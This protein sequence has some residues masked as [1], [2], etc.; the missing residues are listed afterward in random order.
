MREFVLELLHHEVHLVARGVVGLNVNFILRNLSEVL[1][2]NFEFRGFQNAVANRL[3]GHFQLEASDG[4]EVELDGEVA[5]LCGVHFLDVLSNVAQFCFLD[6]SFYNSS[7]NHRVLVHEH[8]CDDRSADFLGGVDDFL[9]S[10]NTQGY[11]H[12]SN[13]SEMESF[14]GHLSGWLS[15]RLGSNSAT[16]FA[17]HH[18]C[19]LVSSP[20]LS[21]KFFELTSC[22]VSEVPQKLFVLEFPLQ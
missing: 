21:N 2:L 22:Q 14:E 13:S 15:N 5:A 19:F 9:N 10:G 17:G 7:R 16:S 20:Y 18:H 3:C 12:T 4:F 6:P 1:L 8:G 11:V